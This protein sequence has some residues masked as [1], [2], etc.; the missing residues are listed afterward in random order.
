MCFFNHNFQKVKKP[1]WKARASHCPLFPR[2]E[3]EGVITLL[4]WPRRR[5]EWSPWS[6]QTTS[7]PLCNTLAKARQTCMR[8][9]GTGAQAKKVLAPNLL[10]PSWE[11][12]ARQGEPRRS[13][14]LSLLERRGQV[15]LQE[16]EGCG[17]RKLG[18]KIQPGPFRE[19]EGV[20]H[21]IDFQSRK[22]ISAFCCWAAFQFQSRIC[23]GSP[24]SLSSCHL[25]ASSVSALLTPTLAPLP[26]SWSEHLF[27]PLLM[28]SLICPF[29]HSS[30]HPVTQDLT[31]AKNTG[32][33]A[34]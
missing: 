7:V 8:H 14:R 18:T 11:P 2:L 23:L 1:S 34:I 31:E 6:P 33:G 29:T 3:E 21:G 15:L 30:I 19:V 26:V 25:P 22:K 32:P 4:S 17:G 12:G 24:L 13:S 10:T 16:E 9:R 27:A 20:G 28:H 5:S